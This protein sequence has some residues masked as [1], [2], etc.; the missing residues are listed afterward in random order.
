MV[1]VFFQQSI[2]YMSDQLSRTKLHFEK[3]NYIFLWFA[4]K[5]SRN[6]IHFICVFV[7]NVIKQG[8]GQKE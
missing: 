8:G 1:V 3:Q 5:R 6:I 7:F 2:G 4:L